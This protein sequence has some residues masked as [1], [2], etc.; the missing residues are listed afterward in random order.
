[1]I[2]NHELFYELDWEIQMLPCAWLRKVSALTCVH[3]TE[4]I[5]THAGVIQCSM[6][7]VAVKNRNSGT[8]LLRTLDI[9]IA[10]Y[11][12]RLGPSGKFA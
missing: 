7:G 6:I 2:L 5:N 3:E 8:P 1:M 9:R 11:P 10:D 12:D 4:K